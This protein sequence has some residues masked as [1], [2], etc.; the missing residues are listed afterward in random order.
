LNSQY[1]YGGSAGNGVT[2]Y[3]IGM[4]LAPAFTAPNR[5]GIQIDHPP[6]GDVLHGE[7]PSADTGTKVEMDTAL[8]VLEPPLPDHMAFLSPPVLLQ[9]RF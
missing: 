5:P 6:S 2:V 9:S 8:T 3:T 7:K 1:E 4:P